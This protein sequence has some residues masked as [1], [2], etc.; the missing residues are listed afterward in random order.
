MNQSPAERM[1]DAARSWLGSLTDEQ[2]HQALAPWPSDDERHRWYYTPTNHGGLPLAHM[3]PAQQ[4]RA[5]QLIATGLS[6]P[7]YV[8]ATT[9]MGL[10]NVLDQVEDW[11]V[12]WGRERGRD[13]Q[14]YW[15]KVFGE[16]DLSA[17]W[18]WR[19]GGHHI[20][21]Q[22]FVV[23]GDVRSSS[24]S[25]LGADPAESPLLGGHLLRPL[26]AAED[27]ARE[28]VRSLDDTQTVDTVICSVAPVDL[29]GGNRPHLND[30]DMLMPL[31]ELWRGQFT[32]ARL[33]DKVHAMHEAAEANAGARPEHHRAVRLS[34][35]PKGIPATALTAGQR[36][37]L[38]AVLNSFIDRIPE[39]LAEREAEKFAGDNLNAV[40]FAWAGGIDRGQPHYYRLQAPR[41]LAEYD[42]TQR[43]VNHIHT[44]WRDPTAD[45]G[46][47][48]L[49]LHRANF[50]SASQLI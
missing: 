17:P 49:A 27:L 20:S 42:N 5:M 19:F 4:S 48:F 12:D 15:L 3:S 23:Q 18:S 43:D 21:L 16:P 11:Q 35:T 9:I 7:G 36:E 32:D 45:F 22:H 47:D 2:R 38:R 50:H 14:L 31:P 25:F 1:V 13:P 8:T 39:E 37:L 10:E 40:H 44:V 28:L 24:P 46:H 30:G 6:K 34:T 41:L 29:V 33:R 26:G